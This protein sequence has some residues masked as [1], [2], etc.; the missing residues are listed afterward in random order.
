M[1][2]EGLILMIA[3]IFIEGS[4]L[5]LSYLYY[6]IIYCKSKIN[7]VLLCFFTVQKLNKQIQ[8]QLSL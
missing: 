8:S 3:L 6:F 4:D 2:L 5:Q 1:I 7:I